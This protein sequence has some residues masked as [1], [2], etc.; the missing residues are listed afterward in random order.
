MS[1][2]IVIRSLVSVIVLPGV[3]A[4]LIP[5]L[6]LGPASGP[7][8]AAWVGLLPLGFGLVIFTWCVFE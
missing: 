1:L 2:Q 7:D 5:W 6:I 4:V 3:A 8:G